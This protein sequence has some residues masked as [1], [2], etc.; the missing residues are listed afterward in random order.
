[1]LKDGMD[2]VDFELYDHD[3]KKVRL[4]ELQGKVVLV[5]YPG[6]FT[7]VCEKELCTFRDMLAKFNNVNATVLG[8]SVDTPFSNKAFAEKNKLTFRLLSDFSGTI[9]KQYGGVHENFAGVPNYTV[10]KR[11][12]FVIENMKVIY[13][14]VTDNPGNEPPY[15]ELQKVL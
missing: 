10:A 13:S 15:E 9:S 11:A 12:V 5:F 2:A 3:L 7:S 14:W 8:I 6:A 1:M 4:S